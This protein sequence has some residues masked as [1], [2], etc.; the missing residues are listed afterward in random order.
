[1]R[2]RHFGNTANNAYHNVRL[3]EQYAQIESELPIRMYG[4]QHAIS[5]PAWEAV[6]FDVPSAAWVGQPDWSDLPEAVAIN[7]RYSDIVPPAPVSAEPVPESAPGGIG[8]LV[9]AARTRVFGPLRGKRW[10]QPLISLRDRQMLAARPAI[11]EVDG[12]L[13]LLYGSG[14]LFSSQLPR[15][16]HH[17]V[18]LEHG[19]IRWIADGHAEEKAF[20]DAY[21]AQVQGAA[22]LWVT[23]LDPRTLEV[24]EDVAPGRWSAFPHPFIPDDRVPFAEVPEER[25]DL[26]RQTASESLILLPASQNW[27][28]DHDKGSMTALL[29]FVELRRTGLD[30]GLVAIEWGHQ[31][32]ESKEFLDRSGVGAN[33]VWMPPMARFPLQRMMANVDVVWDQFGLEVFGALALRTIEQ[34]TP[35]VSRGLAPAGNHFIGGPV[36]WSAAA[37]TDEIVRETSRVLEAMGSRGRAAVIETTRA[38]YRAWLFARHSPKLTAALQRDRYAEILDG[39]FDPATVAKDEWAQRADAAA[40]EVGGQ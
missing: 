9:T 17:T 32:A 27:S 10:A 30:V 25:A 39:T 22:H 4:L 36:P 8:A 3:L 18:C 20:R 34:G 23:N 21:R 37:T 26:L 35:L 31:V 14:S 12:A 2:V 15:P 19:T 24:A 33:V 29:A 38:H 1:M 7:S 5:A 40:R 28:K 11:D 6:D 13:N 16:A